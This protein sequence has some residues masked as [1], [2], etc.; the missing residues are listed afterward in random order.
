[1]PRVTIDGLHTDLYSKYLV[2]IDMAHTQVHE[3]NL[4]SC[5]YVQLVSDTNDRTIIA[6]KTPS[7]VDIHII[8]RVAAS[9][10]ATLIIREA[11]TISA[12]VG[13]NLT[14][15]NR[16][17]D[18]TNTSTI[19]STKDATINKA[20][21]FSETD[22]GEVTGGTE[23]YSE[24]IGA[25]RKGQ[26]VAGAARGEYEYILKRGTIYS[27]ELKSFDANDNNHHVELDW[28]ENVDKRGIL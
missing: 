26:A 14:V 12:S 16:K 28:Y 11:P 23:L 19:L 6:L 13:T 24:H 1:M 9:A 21:Y 27:V 22:M 20:T 8:V 25:G 10:A 5:H 2:L 4:F 18:S 3:G 17:R 7:D 15:F